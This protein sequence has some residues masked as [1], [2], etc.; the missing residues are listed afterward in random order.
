MT[1]ITKQG[2]VISKLGK[3]FRCGAI[4]R[5]RPTGVALRVSEQAPQNNPSPGP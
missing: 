5:V 3:E 4:K 2:L 1:R